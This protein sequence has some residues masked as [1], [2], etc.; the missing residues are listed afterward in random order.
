MP[1]DV[2]ILLSLAVSGLGV[3]ALQRL[4]ARLPA[5]GRIWAGGRT[6]GGVPPLA[7]TAGEFFAACLQNRPCFGDAAALLTGAQ[8][9]AL[10]MILTARPFM[11]ALLGL[12]FMVL[13]T[14]L[15]RA[16]EK[17]L[18]EPLVLADACLIPQG[19]RYPHLYVPF[20][21]LKTMAAG[22]A[23]LCLCLGLLLAAEPPLD[24]LLRG[25][26]LFGLALLFLLPIACLILMRRGHLPG[27]AS[28]LLRLC[29][30][31]HDAGRDAA[32]N[33]PLAAALLHPVLLGRMER[34]QPDFMRDYSAR[35]AASRFPDSMEQ[36]LRD[37]ETTPP[38]KLPHIV[39]IQAESFCDIRKYVDEPLKSALR[40][41]LPNWDKLKAEG[42]AFDPPENAYG[43]YTMRTEFSMLTGLH[44]ADLGPWAFNPYL[45]AARQPLWSLA[46]HLRDKGYDT[47][48][49]HPYY[50]DFFGRNKV[51]PNLGFQRFLGIEE[52][53]HLQ[54]FGPYVSDLALGEKIV[55][56]L[57]T[58][59]NP[60]F[61]FAITME[62]HGPWLEG[63]LKET[64]IIAPLRHIDSALR[65]G[66]MRMYLSHLQHMDALFA[67]LSIPVGRSGKI[68]A[69]GDHTPGV[70][71][72]HT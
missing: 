10:F 33:G 4:D 7:P 55:Q 38:D 8:A 44:A 69:Y 24:A 65:S 39:L 50:K 1:D 15:N 45:L 21:P 42:R 29:P 30:V 51:I 32:R 66:E 62:A 19:F 43:A 48:C 23:L 11:A 26:P 47:L 67:A 35:P 27:P 58:S 16:K 22:A 61:C 28:L 60:V 31:S 3:A 37:L 70:A 40:D 9:A 72:L 49:I 17:A 68:W 59:K 34:E 57:E 63:R 20:L 71:A 13:M 12:A 5:E 41:F 25:G 2:P 64:E 56:E 53:D 36:M 14:L 52:L 18:H 54:K 6:D 46:R